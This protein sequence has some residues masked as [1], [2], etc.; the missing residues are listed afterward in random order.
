MTAHAD[1]GPSQVGMELI[2]ILVGGLDH[3]EGVAWG[4][5]GMIYASGEAGQV[6]RVDPSTR[7]VAE[8][9]STHG[10]TLGLALDAHANV[11]ACDPNRHAV[12]RVSPSG[13]VDQYSAGAPDRPMRTPNYP[14]FDASGNLYVSDSGTWRRGGGCVFRIAPGGSTSVWTDEPGRFTNGLALSPDDRYLYVVESTRPGVVRI[15]IR[16][17]GS[18]GSLEPVVDV[19]FTVPDGLAFDADGNLYIACYRPDRIYRLAPNGELSVLAEDWQG[20]LLAAPT[21]IA[22]G[23]PDL[24]DLLIASL[25]RWHLGRMRLAVSG[26]P[27]HYPRLT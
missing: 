10:W 18:A 17:D 13:G 5:D 3:P 26:H 25:G 27:L 14:C 7:S 2:E 15:P 24:R 22:F 11:Y 16:A 1:A 6:Y 20:T 4:P 21:N 23:G 19:P 12:F 9:G 8:I